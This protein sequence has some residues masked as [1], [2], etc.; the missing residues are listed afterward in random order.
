[1]QVV[2]HFSNLCNMLFLLSF[3]YSQTSK[4]PSTPERSAAPTLHTVFCTIR[5]GRAIT[6]ISFAGIPVFS[7]AHPHTSRG[8]QCITL[9]T[10]SRAVS[11]IEVLRERA[12]HSILLCF[13]NRNVHCGHTKGNY[14]SLVPTQPSECKFCVSCLE[15]ST[16]VLI[17][18]IF[19]VGCSSMLIAIAGFE[20]DSQAVICVRELNHW[21]L[22]Q[23]PIGLVP[24]IN[25][26]ISKN[27]ALIMEE[28]LGW[29]HTGLFRPMW[30]SNQQIPDLECS[31]QRGPSLGQCST[32][33]DSSTPW[34]C[35]EW[36]TS[37]TFGRYSSYQQCTGSHCLPLQQYYRQTLLGSCNV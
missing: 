34:I 33:S 4:L 2:I 29:G 3:C 19:A 25:M 8:L 31:L 22:H 9:C 30:R 32:S 37:H 36:C 20:S 10:G 7:K 16:C 15:L 17:M 12:C 24:W 6:T 5:C 26:E 35:R 23:L 1:M 14:A 27:Q 11:A 13:T 18:E 21:A 28:G